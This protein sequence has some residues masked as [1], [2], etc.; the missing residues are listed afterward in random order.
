MPSSQ[1]RA[2]RLFISSDGTSSGT[3]T[4]VEALGD[5][6]VTPGKSTERVVTKNLTTSFVTDAGFE[7]SGEFIEQLPLGAAQ[8]LLW[9]AADNETPVYAWVEST[10]TGGLSF[11]G[12]FRV[13]ITTITSPSEG[14][15]THQFSL[16]VDGAITRS[17]IA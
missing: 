15:Q 14:V 4:E 7:V 8:E 10:E 11:A 3:K 6:T 1:A 2:F 13:G 17:Q 16:S 5:L 12:T 9:T